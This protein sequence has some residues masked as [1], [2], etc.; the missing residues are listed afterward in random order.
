MK[1]KNQST[2]G[3]LRAVEIAGSQVALGRA[4]GH[5]QALVFKWL[6]SSNGL[7]PIYCVKIEQKFGVRRQDLRPDDWHL[8]WPE[9][10]TAPAHKAQPAIDSV[11]AKEAA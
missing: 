6:N 2:V 7:G 10:I 8:I 9:L 3:L 11:A 1:P 5:S 4:L